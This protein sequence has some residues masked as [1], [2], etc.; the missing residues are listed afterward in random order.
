MFNKCNDNNIDIPYMRSEIKKFIQSC[1]FCQKDRL[2][3]PIVTNINP[4]VVT[5]PFA[6]IEIDFITRLPTDIGNITCICVIICRM[7]SYIELFPAKEPTA[8]SAALSML[9]VC[10]R[11]GLIL[12]YRCDQGPSFIS[13][14]FQEFAKLFGANII[15]GI[16][17]QPKI[18]GIV[19]RAN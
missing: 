8:I 11:Y 14:T 15:F 4:I 17:Y 12:T 5:E 16:P 2:N 9:S 13:E 1:P 3:I 19:E 6:E 18:Q 10:A 7:T